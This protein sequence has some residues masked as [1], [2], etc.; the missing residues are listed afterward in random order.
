MSKTLLLAVA[1]AVVTALSAG[2]A[3][4]YHAYSGGCVP[5][6]YCPPPPLPYTTYCACPSSISTGCD[7]ESS[8]NAIVLDPDS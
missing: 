1:F 3:A 5:C 8:N 2:C 7:E 6:V 4:D